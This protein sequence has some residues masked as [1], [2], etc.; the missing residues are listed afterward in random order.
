[1]KQLVSRWWW[2]LKRDFRLSVFKRETGRDLKDLGHAVLSI[3][4]SVFC[5]VMFLILLVIRWPLKP[6]TLIW[7]AWRHPE[8]IDRYRKQEHS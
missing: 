5:A 6:F 4:E 1:M 7:F 2:C 8:T 3:F